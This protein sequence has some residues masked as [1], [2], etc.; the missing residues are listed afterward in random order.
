MTFLPS[1]LHSAEVDR[2]P[3]ALRAQYVFYVTHWS[4]CMFYFI[5]SLYNLGQDTWIGRHFDNVVNLPLVD[6]QEA[7]SPP[8]A[9]TLCRCSRATLTPP[10]PSIAIAACE[11]LQ[12]PCPEANGQTPR[13]PQ[14]LT[15]PAPGTLLYMHKDIAC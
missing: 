11:P 14:V 2:L 4:A 15:A 12:V 9:C 3:C 8:A 5:A 10:R 1:K 7:C 13:G 6:R